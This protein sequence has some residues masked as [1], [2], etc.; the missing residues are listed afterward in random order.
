MWDWTDEANL[1]DHRNIGMSVLGGV[2]MCYL[3]IHRRGSIHV[4]LKD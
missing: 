1:R 3:I 4:V 2:V